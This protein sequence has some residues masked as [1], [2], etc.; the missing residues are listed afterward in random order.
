MEIILKHQCSKCNSSMI[1]HFINNLG[2]YGIRCL[3][4]GHEIKKIIK[5][6]PKNIDLSDKKTIKR[7]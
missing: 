5:N 3:K 6:F 7:F 4:C 2:E 1:E